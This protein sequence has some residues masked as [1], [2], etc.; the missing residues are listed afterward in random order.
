M[1]LDSLF[2][3]IIGIMIILTY[4]KNN[5][6]NFNNTTSFSGINRLTTL[7]N[8]ITRTRSVNTDVKV[9]GDIYIGTSF[10]LLPVGVIVAY[11]GSVA[12][13]GWAIC[14]GSNSTPDLRDK[15]IIGSGNKYNLSSG[16]G[17]STVQ[18]QRKHIP[19]HTHTYGVPQSNGSNVGSIGGNTSYQYTI[20]Q[21][22]NSGDGQTS[23]ANGTGIKIGDGN[24]KA[25]PFNIL[26]PYYAFCYIV[27]L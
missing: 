12:P 20:S 7:Y 23:S 15:F 1:E 25:T 18:L 11:N 16:G 21:T 4:C 8:N 5:N 27:K 14:D 3:I 17:S 13:F 19:P 6:E 10:N 22:A 26:P 9:L 2:I 24:G